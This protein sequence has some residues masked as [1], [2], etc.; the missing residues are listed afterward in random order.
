MKKS[1]KKMD[2]ALRVALTEVCEH[3]KESHTGFEWLTHQ[4]NYADFP[5]SLTITCV[6][7]THHHM[8]QADKASIIT[9][10]KQALQPLN[11]SLNNT[12]KQIRFDSEE[13]CTLEHQGRWNKRLS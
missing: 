4:V 9:S 8:E 13:S 12:D 11:V 1:D 10:L 5:R 7:D 6:F 2:N 3:A